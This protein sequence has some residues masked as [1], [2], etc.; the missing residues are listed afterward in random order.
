MT[1]TAHFTV[2][3]PLLSIALLG[4]ACAHM[5]HYQLGDIDSF[6]GRLEPFTV[7]VDETGF[8]AQEALDIARHT[9]ATH[10][11]R[12]RVSDAQDIL[13]LFQVGYSTGDATF[14]DDW[15]DGV[16]A[17]VLTRCPTGRLTGIS[18]VR[19]SADY[20]VVSGEI[21]TIKGYCVR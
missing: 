17:K 8:D 5:H 14:N 16:L 7:R 15:A 2:R 21:V 1:W 9:S 12:Q 10:A 13:A 18:V 19:E 6:E 4:T 11:D 3:A 20:P